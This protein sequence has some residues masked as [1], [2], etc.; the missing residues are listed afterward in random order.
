MISLFQ[1]VK[2]LTF[3][4]FLFLTILF[5][6]ILFVLLQLSKFFFRI[7]FTEILTNR[8]GHLALNP[9]CYIVNKNKSSSKIK[10]LDLFCESKYG[11]CNKE[12][13]K[14]WKKKLQFYQD[15]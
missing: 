7:R 3:F 8:Y 14:L 9:E 11:I 10:Y 6:P 13:F 1:K 2:T 12:L 4:L 15:I 5:F